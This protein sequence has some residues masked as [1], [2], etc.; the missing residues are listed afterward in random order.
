MVK[1]IKLF[2]VI[3]IVIGAAIMGFGINYF[4]I[5]NGLAEGGIMG[6]SLILN[7]LL[8]WNPGL[9]SFLINIPLLLIGWKVMGRTSFIYAIIGAVSLSF[10]LYA[11]EFASK[12]LDD[13]LLA[14]L[15]AGAFVGIGLGIV[16]R[17]G[18]MTDGMDVVALLCRQ[19]WGWSLGKT[20][21]LTD[22]IIIVLS[23][24]YLDLQRAMYTLIAITVGARLIDFVQEGS[25][26]AKAVTII[27]NEP[28]KI[29]AAVL[30]QMKRGVTFLS[31]K[32]AYTREPKEILYCVISRNETGKLKNIVKEA[33][34]EAFVI[35]S[36][37]HEVVGKGWS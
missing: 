13:P 10:F 37:A 17:Y 20:L 21:F 31:G 23:L 11:F 18:G 12:K 15:Y 35:F 22:M 24:I 32:G 30:R 8:G 26:S 36:D 14:S 28:D 1:N 19:Y 6:V 4:N 7:Y 2:N 33:D 16:F 34:P 9:S 5:A 25:Y 27:S 29:A 3:A